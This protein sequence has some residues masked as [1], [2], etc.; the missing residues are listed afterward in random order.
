MVMSAVSSVSTFGRVG[1]GDALAGGRLDIDVIDAV[2]EAGDQL[3]LRSGLVDQRGIDPVGDGRHQHIG[4]A[5]GGDSSSRLR[6]A[7]VDIQLGIEQLAH[8]GL[9]DVGQFAGD[10]D[11]RSFLRSSCARLPTSSVRR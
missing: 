10:V 6:G 8:A 2:G 11:P 3:E 4:A 9:D 7:I 5:H 1:D